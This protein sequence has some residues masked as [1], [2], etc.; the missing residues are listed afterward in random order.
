MG[1]EGRQEAGGGWGS[2]SGNGKGAA[3]IRGSFYVRFDRYLLKYFFRYFD[4][5]S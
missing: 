1:C 4:N 2:G 3:G 5:A